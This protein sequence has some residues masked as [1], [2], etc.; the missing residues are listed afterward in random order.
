MAG[1]WNG[2]WQNDPQWG[3]ANGGFTLKVT[4]DTGT[5]F[6]GT[7]DVTGP[8]CVRHGTASGTVSGNHISMGWVATGI[9]D[10]EYEGTISGASMS[11]T[12]TAIACGTETKISGTWSAKK[13]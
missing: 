11:G 13:T 1:T 5:A 3:S 7:V 10:V 9:R 2:V 8:T 4:Q 12:W 6:S